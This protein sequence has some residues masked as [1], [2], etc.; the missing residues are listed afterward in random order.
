MNKVIILLEDDANR[1]IV[2]GFLNHLNINS[3]AITILPLAGGW[4]KVGD[5][6]EK[7]IIP[8]MLKN[9]GIIAIL[10]FDFDKHKKKGNI[11]NFSYVQGKIPKNLKHRV[12]SLGALHEPEKL[13][14]ELGK[15]E[16]IGEKLAEDCYDNTYSLWQHSQFKHNLK[17]LNR[18][19]HVVKPV[20]FN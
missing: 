20:I 16:K 15:Y 17:E 8:E 4:K 18:M 13:K 19:I 5:N 14:K 11:D 9:S 12:L 3:R 7:N 1:Q 6:F 2:N 10:V